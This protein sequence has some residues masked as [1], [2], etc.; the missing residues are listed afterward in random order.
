MH[1]YFLLFL[2]ILPLTVLSQENITVQLQVPPGRGVPL[3]ESFMAIITNSGEPAEVFLRGTVQEEEDGLIFEGSSSLATLE[4]GVTRLNRRNLSPIQPTQNISMKDRYQKYVTRASK[5]PP[6]SYRFCLQ[7]VQ[8]ETEEVIAQDCYEKTIE[9]YLPPSL[10][11]PARGSEVRQNQPIFTWSPV[12][13]TNASNISYNLEIVEQQGN[14]SPIA[15]F[16]SN[17]AWY[18]EEGL[19]SPLFHYPVAARGFIRNQ[20]YAWKVTAYIED[21]KIS[22]SEVWSFTYQQEADTTAQEEEQD[23]TQTLLPEQYARLKTNVHSGYYLLDDFTLRFIYENSYATT[24]LNCRLENTKNEIV[25]RDIIKKKQHT[26][27]NFNRLNLSSRARPGETYWLRCAGAT[28]ESRELKFRIREQNG[29][30]V[31]RD[32][33][34][35]ENLIEFQE[36][37]FNNGGNL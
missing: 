35:D 15:A 18:Q 9:N 14:Q 24:Q 10:I 6:G 36:G 11:S 34:I 8:A 27:L 22:E 2:L 3:D 37:I 25:A 26:G 23:T 16:A 20:Q 31:I 19:T 33:N 7:I 30:N 1:R 13:G 5:F 4:H 29:E 32:M 21:S 28:G 12:P 17:P